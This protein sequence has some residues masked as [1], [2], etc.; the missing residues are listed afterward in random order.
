MNTQSFKEFTASKK[1][2]SVVPK[3]R[4]NT[5]GYPFVTLINDK[6]EAENLYFSKS[7]SELLKAG[8]AIVKGFFSQFQVAD[9]INAEGE[10][11]VKLISNSE[12]VSIGEL[13]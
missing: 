11:R 1:F 6:N 10:A 9:T 4:A 2:V 8:D 5:N 13:L 7:A 3:I 12:R